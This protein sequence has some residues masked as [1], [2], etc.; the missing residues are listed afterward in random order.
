M[1]RLSG[2]ETPGRWCGIDTSFFGRDASA[3]FTVLIRTSF[4]QAVA[5]IGLVG[6]TKVFVDHGQ[7]LAKF[8]SGATD[9]IPKKTVHRCLSELPL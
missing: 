7:V 1:V 9:I 6:S 8:S 2:S 3:E 5:R 4:E